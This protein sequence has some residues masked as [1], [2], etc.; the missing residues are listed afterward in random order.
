M[1]APLRRR[2]GEACKRRA[3]R[4]DLCG[5]TDPHV[6]LAVSEAE[7]K[8][9]VDDGAHEFVYLAAKIEGF[10]NAPPDDART[11][12]RLSSRVRQDAD[13]SNGATLLSML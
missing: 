8:R 5:W 9:P 6:H 10:D 13:G 7:N 3:R 4:S 2:R 11:D 12:M 1:G